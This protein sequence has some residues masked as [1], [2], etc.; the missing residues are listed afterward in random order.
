[1]NHPA[2]EGT[3]FSYVVIP[4]SANTLSLIIS[5]L[6]I[7]LIGSFYI[8]TIRKGHEWGDDFSMYIQQAKNLAHH[9]SFSHS[10]YIFNPRRPYVGPKVYPPGYPVLLAPVYAI[11]GMDLRAMKIENI[12]FFMTTLVI[13]YFLFRELLPLPY[14]VASIAIIGFNGML[15]AFKDVI[16]SEM[17][18][19]LFLFLSF[20]W[21]R[22]EDRFGRY[23]HRVLDRTVAI[24]L[25]FSCYCIRANGVLLIPALCLS[26]VARHK[27]LTSRAS[28]IALG[29]IP[30]FISLHFL[31]PSD[32]AYMNLMESGGLHPGNI[33]NNLYLYSQKLSYFWG[34]DLSKA[35]RV[36]FFVSFTALSFYGYILRMR[37]DASICEF[38]TGLHLALNIVLPF[39]QGF[40]YLIPIIPL[41]ILYGLVGAS[42]ALTH[43]PREIRRY[44]QF[45]AALMIA[46]I[47]IASYAAARYGP[48]P[49]GVGKKETREFF[50]YIQNNTDPKSVI[51]FRKPRA[52]GLFTQRLA[53][54]Y[55]EDGDDEALWEYIKAIHATHLATSPIDEPF[56]NEFIKRN[57]PL[58]GNRFVNADFALYEINSISSLDK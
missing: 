39:S 23:Q 36:P 41:Y 20:F 8:I 51:I 52:L 16:V 42:N 55:P 43:I 22:S 19:L 32:T 2:D 10:Y 40:R 25:I 9:D 12:L 4:H 48:I 33:W 30:L 38:Y 28:F 3:S 57:M 45:C 58:L 26:E 5:L 7:L 31:Y 35:L 14:L 46:A 13:C 21:I 50:S 17:S 47:Y 1:M 34:E 56:W 29:F 6:L 15:W 27:R 11:F 37:R 18:Y 44:A 53:S 49:E 54:A 24:F